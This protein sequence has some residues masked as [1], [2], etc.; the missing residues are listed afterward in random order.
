MLVAE[1]YGYLEEM[2]PAIEPIRKEPSREKQPG[3]APAPKHSIL[4]KVLTIGMVLICFAAACFAVFRYTLISENHDRILELEDALEKEYVQQDKMKV[5][6]A[7]SE[8]LNN[9]E[10]KATADLGMQYPE[11]GQV[12]YVELPEEPDKQAEHVDAGKASRPGK[13]IW[14]RLLGLSN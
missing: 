7:G 10:F 13:S 8:D 2:E 5:E 12:Q 4:N 6:L 9:I 11:E 3:T 14:N 1:K